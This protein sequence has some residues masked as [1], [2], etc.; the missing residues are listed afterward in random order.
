MGWLGYWVI[1]IIC[2][3]IR[4]ESQGDKYLE[5]IY[6]A[7]SRAIFTFWHGRIFPAT[8]YWRN[9]GIIVMASMNLDGE[10]M[11]HCIQR[12]GYSAVRGSSSRGGLKALSAMVKEIQ[13]GRDAAFTIDGPRGPRHVA[14][15]GPVILARKTGA[16]ISCFHVSM[17]HKIQLNSWDGFQIP[18]PFTRAIVLKAPPIWVPSNASE[19]KMRQIHMRMQQVLEELCEQGN[20][21]WN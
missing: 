20:H 1:T 5:Q 11:T 16:A 17:K 3:T 13:Q 9:R 2:R 4:W 15:V 14:K 19:D 7:G 21:W 18:I 12:H 10:A 6:A 8:W